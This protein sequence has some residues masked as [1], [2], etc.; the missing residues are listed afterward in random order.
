MKL[1]EEI[2]F[3]N[4][5]FKGKFVVENVKPYY[6]PLIEPQIL[7]RHRFRSNIKIPN[8]EIEYEI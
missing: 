3:L 8:I 1:Y 6:K 5:F 4:T 2:I 7:G